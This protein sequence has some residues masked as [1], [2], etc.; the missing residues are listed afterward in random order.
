AH[1][2][3]P[4]TFDASGSTDEAGPPASFAWDVD[5]DGVADGQ[6]A[7]FMYTYAAAGTYTAQLT[8]TDVAG[9]RATTT[10]TVVV[11]PPLPPPAPPARPWRRCA[12]AARHA[13]RCAARGAT[14]ACGWPT[15]RADPGLGRPDEALRHQGRRPDAERRAY[16]QV[17]RP[18]AHDSR[19]ARVEGPLRG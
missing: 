15:R 9:A 17:E 3:D 7:T 18:T 10:R 6:G 19:R 1:A 14:R 4:V 8:V 11:A 16:W 13:A 5:G 12:S 2:G